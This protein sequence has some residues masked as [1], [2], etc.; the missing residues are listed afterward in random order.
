M[1]VG[2]FFS[3]VCGVGFVPPSRE[4]HCAIWCTLE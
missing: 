1:G 4:T 3:Y 2:G